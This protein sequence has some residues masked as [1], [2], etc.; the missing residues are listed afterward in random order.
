MLGRK[1]TAIL[2]FSQVYP[3]PQAALE[4]L[5]RVKVK[6][7]AESNATAQFARLIRCETGLEF[8]AKI[9]TYS[10][11]PLTPEDV[12]EGLQGALDRE[13]KTHGGL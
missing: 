8:D 3:L 6:I 11:L 10:G 13:E 2:H 4:P 1:D 7:I 12:F 5:G 9:L